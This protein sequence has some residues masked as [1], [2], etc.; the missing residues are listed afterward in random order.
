[1]PMEVNY[2]SLHDKCLSKPNFRPPINI[3][4]PVSMTNPSSLCE[5]HL[6]VFALHLC[7]EE[8]HQVCTPVFS[9]HALPTL[10]SACLPNM[11]HVTG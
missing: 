2:T 9:L 6:H 5:I 7:V 1:M 8:I 3:T 11:A 4:L 10:R